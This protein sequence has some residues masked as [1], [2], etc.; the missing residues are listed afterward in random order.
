MLH[1]LCFSDKITCVNDTQGGEHVGKYQI[2]A[3]RILVIAKKTARNRMI[4]SQ[5]KTAIR[6]FEEALAAENFEEA[7]TRLRFVEKK[8]HQAAAKGTIHKAKASRKV[9][10]LAQRLN[11]AM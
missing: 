3:K 2:C 8:L 4:K 1:Y 10:R 7:K 9:S 6:R 5:L 11:K